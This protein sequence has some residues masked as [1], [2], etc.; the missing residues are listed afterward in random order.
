MFTNK[1]K[2]ILK[3][4]LSTHKSIWRV[5]KGHDTAIN[6]YNCVTRRNEPFIVRNKDVVTWYTCGPTVYDAAHLGHASCY[7]KLDII[8]RILRRHFALNVVTCMNITD[9]DDKIIKR[10]QELRTDF[11]EVSRKF[12]KDFWADLSALSIPQPDIVLR[13]TENIPLIIQFI[14]KL[15]ADGAAYTGGDSSVYFDTS[16]SCHPPGRLQNI[17]DSPP[18]SSN[19]HKRRQADFA[20]W[21][22]VKSPLE[23]CFDSP[24]GKGRPG[25]HIECS[26]L[27]SHVF[28]AAIDVH[29][30][31]LDLRFP[32]HENEEMQSCAFHGRPQWVNYW[33]HTGHLHL[34]NAAKMS[35]SL[36]NTISIQEMLEETKPEV[37]RFACAKSHYSN[38]VEYSVELIET[39]ASALAAVRNLCVSFSEL[40]RGL[41]KPVLN[42]DVL[43]ELL[44]KSTKD[45]HAALCDDFNTPQVIQALDRV[46]STVNSM[47]HSAASQSASGGDLQYVLAL[48][49]L[50]RDSL[51]LFGIELDEARNAHQAQDS[52][53]LI[54]K[55]VN[56]RQDVRA[57]GLQEKNQT[58]LKLCDGLRDDLKPSGLTIKDHGKTSSWSKN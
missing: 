38:P 47:L 40:K 5:P 15:Q 17:S 26:S 12:E 41:L 39:S 3:R 27:A 50:V 36:K 23:P 43:S 32:H 4:V 7:V 42:N 57:V 8:Q 20:L 49:N 24:W 55:L 13:V 46:A 22:A 28:G 37:F 52:V 45:I 2:L 33:I 25:W 35:K 56:F 10:A 16:Q 21:K 58:L 6:I 18:D 30:G 44:G 11:S 19:P 54:D 48:N 34:K 29:A 14:E 31:G 53:E 9:I 1:P 51:S